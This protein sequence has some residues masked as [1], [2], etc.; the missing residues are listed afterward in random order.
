[1]IFVAERTI[2]K[3]L[4]NLILAAILSGKKTTY[5]KQ[6]RIKFELRLKNIYTFNNFNFS[7]FVKSVY[8]IFNL[9]CRNFQ[10]IVSKQCIL[11]SFC[12]SKNRLCNIS[13]TWRISRKYWQ[14]LQNKELYIGLVL[15][16]EISLWSWNH[17][18]LECSVVSGIY[19]RIDSLLFF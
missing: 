4:R 16:F 15:D 1:M 10:Y 14:S 2:G 7:F 8:R 11:S 5:Y 18:F 13:I 12:H 9:S 6:N 17:L 3:I 19:R